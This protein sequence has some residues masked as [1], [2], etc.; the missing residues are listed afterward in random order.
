M[1]KNLTEM[2]F[3]LDKSGSMA[4]LEKDTVGGF[5]SLIAS[6]RKEEGEALV[7]AVLFNTES[8]VI[9]DREPIDG[10]RELTES[11]YVPCGCTALLDAVGDAVKHISTVHKYARDEDVPEKTIFIIT[12]DGMENSS[13]RYSF[14]EIKR[15]ISS[16]QEKDGWEFMFLGANIDVAST[17]KDMGIRAENQGEYCSDECGTAV[18]FRAVSR[19]VAGFRGS[20]PASCEWKQEMEND[21]RSRGKR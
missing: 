12:T 3:I 2:V 11:D 4:G 10:V 18:M 13:R 19:R 5:N 16:R 20:A 1:K 21:A 8:E 14:K 6:Q 17:A 7:S 15:L 9:L